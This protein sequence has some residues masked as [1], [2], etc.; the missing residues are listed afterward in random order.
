MAGDLNAAIKAYDQA[1]SL[2][3]DHSDAASR[4]ARAVLAQSKPTG[5]PENPKDFASVKAF[6]DEMARRGEFGL[7]VRAWDHYLANSPGD[8]RA[9][10]ERGGAHLH[11]GHTPQALADLE[12]ACAMG[13]ADGCKGAQHVRGRAR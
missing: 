13:S 7:I 5:A 8:A 1:L 10:L 9:Y 4:R 2:D 6:D 11:A 3:P 12:K